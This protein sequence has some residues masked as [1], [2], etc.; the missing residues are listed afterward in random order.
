MLHDA[1]ART[2]VLVLCAAL[3]PACRLDLD[4]REL[5]SAC[6]PSETVPSCLDAPDQSDF[7]W[8]QA[9]I[10]T[11][12]C[13]SNACH[14]EGENGQPPDGRIR[15]TRDAS[16]ATLMGADGQ[17]VAATFDTSRQLVVPGQPARS[18]LLFLMRGLDA[19]FGEPPFDPPPSEYGFMPMRSKTLC[20]QKLEAVRRWIEQGALP[21]AQMATRS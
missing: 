16:Y 7:E 14:G 20:C 17:G 15:L 2:A 10:F 8:L 12:N 11:P 9:N 19:E 21:P 3:A 1:H 6:E 18:Y 13:T 5:A 4:T